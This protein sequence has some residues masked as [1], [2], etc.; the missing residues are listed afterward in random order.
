MTAATM[1]V[2]TNERKITIKSVSEMDYD[3]LNKLIVKC[4]FHNNNAKYIKQAADKILTDFKGEVPSKMDDI[5]SF[6]GVGYKMAN[7]L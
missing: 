5:L 7:L 2:L 6:N 3:D 4:N 1:N